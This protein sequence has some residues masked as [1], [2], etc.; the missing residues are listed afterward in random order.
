MSRSRHALKL[1]ALV[2]AALASLG[3]VDSGGDGTSS[4]GC[5][6]GRAASTSTASSSV[7]LAFLRR[8]SKTPAASKSK[9]PAAAPPK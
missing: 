7:F 9:T 8:E 3:R 1:M 2:L 5:V 4:L 6:A